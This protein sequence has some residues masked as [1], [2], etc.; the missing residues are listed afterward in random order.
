MKQG[1]GMILIVAAAL[2]G[3]QPVSPT[4]R[5]PHL[6]EPAP[7]DRRDLELRQLKA[8]V[9]TLRGQ[10]DDLRARC[11]GLVEQIRKLELLNEQLHL[12][13]RVV[14]DAPRQ[15]DQARADLTARTAQMQRLYERITQLE[16]A[17]NI[18]AAQRTTMPSTAPSSAP[19]PE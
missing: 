18:P 2:A 14:G 10:N 8:D 16:R 6:D 3:C 9:V 17:L 1:W 13:L 19:A 4:S 15:R 11:D 7:P 5:T 12:Q